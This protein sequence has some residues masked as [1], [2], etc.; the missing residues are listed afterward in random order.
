VTFRLPLVVT[1]GTHSD[2]HR[3]S[4]F[5]RF[6][7]SPI[8]PTPL[9]PCVDYGTPICSMHVL[10]SRSIERCSI[11]VDTDHCVR[12]LL[13]AAFITTTLL[14]PTIYFPVVNG[15]ALLTS[16]PPAR[17]LTHRPIQTCP[18][19]RLCGVKHAILPRTGYTFHYPY[20]VAPPLYLQPDCTCCLVHG[21]HLLRTVLPVVYQRLVVGP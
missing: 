20:L 15:H 5:V 1:G 7:P 19:T 4:L 2:Y 13:P 14:H 3:R 17:F 8:R 12:L 16:S 11:C 18:Y 6:K 9:N 21:L 10:I